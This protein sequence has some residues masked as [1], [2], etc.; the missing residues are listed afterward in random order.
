[1]AGWRSLGLLLC[2]LLWPHRWLLLLVSLVLLHIF[3]AKPLPGGLPLSPRGRWPHRR[4]QGGWGGPLV[5]CYLLQL[6]LAMISRTGKLASFQALTPKSTQSGGSGGPSMPPICFCLFS[7]A[8]DVSRRLPPWWLKRVVCRRPGAVPPRIQARSFQK[9]SKRPQETE[10]KNS[11]V[12]QPTTPHGRR[13]R[14][15]RYGHAFFSPLLF[16]P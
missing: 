5:E 4:L 11:R 7:S 1:M 15:Q 14:G 16:E 8:L 12:I 9:T 2:Q 13:R 6:L 10:F 3:A